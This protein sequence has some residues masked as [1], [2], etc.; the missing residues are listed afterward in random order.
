MAL[1]AVMLSATGAGFSRCG[2]LAVTR[3]SEDPT[4]DNSGQ[5][6]FLR[7]CESGE[8]WSGGF[9]PV[10]TKPDSY[11]VTFTEDRV[12]I[13]RRDG[14]VDYSSARYWCRR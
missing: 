3:W 11:R 1:T 12:E 6:I 13:V 14:L 4:S 7:D 2:N 10:A 8:I 9:Q 5:A